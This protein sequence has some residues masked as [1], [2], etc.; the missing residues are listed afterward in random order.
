MALI[1]HTRTHKHKFVRLLFAEDYL[2]SVEMQPELFS[3]TVLWIR[4]TSGQQ[5]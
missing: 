3:P 4:A 1:A 5:V 2:K